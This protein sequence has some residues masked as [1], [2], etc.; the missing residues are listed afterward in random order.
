MTMKD[1]IKDD[2]RDQQRNRRSVT[3]AGWQPRALATRERAQRASKPKRRTSAS[4]GL[5]GK[6][7]TAW[8]SE[9]SDSHLR[10]TNQVPFAVAHHEGAT[11]GHG[12]KL[13]ARPHLDVDK[14]HVD[15]AIDTLENL[16][17]DAWEKRK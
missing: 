13:P 15:D 10:M 1:A 3:G 8:K 14:R 5:L 6:A 17:S 4:T 9:V 11:V 16:M 12:A 7:A 2:M